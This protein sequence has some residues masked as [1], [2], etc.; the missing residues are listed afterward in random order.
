MTVHVRG[1][2]EAGSVY[3]DNSPS[4]GFTQI[5]KGTDYHRPVRYQVGPDQDDY[6]EVSVLDEGGGIEVRVGWGKLLV[7]P[8]STNVVHIERVDHRG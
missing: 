3:L 1:E 6:L 8:W 5:Q 2:L 7:F 4:L